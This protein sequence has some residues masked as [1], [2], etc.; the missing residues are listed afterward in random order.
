LVYLLFEHKSSQDRWLVL[1]LLIYVTRIWAWYRKNNGDDCR[2]PMILPI[3][4]YHGEE[5]WSQPLQLIDLCDAEGE[6]RELLGPCQPTLALTLIDLSQ[7]TEVHLRATLSHG[8]A[9]TT[10]TTLLMKSIRGTGLLR[11]FRSWKPVVGQIHAEAGGRQMLELLVQYLL[12]AARE[13]VD[14]DE[15]QNVLSDAIGPE[16]EELI[17]NTGEKLIQKGKERGLE[18]GRKE[19]MREGMQEGR[20]E[21]MKEALANV[22]RSRFDVIPGGIQSRMEAA[23]LETLQHYLDRAI[24]AQSLHEVFES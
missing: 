17:M 14:V 7:I 18:E 8:T 16:S 10:L 21:G 15:L 4:F 1:Q 12:V 3:V 11:R 24:T 23:D 5:R 20:R 2:L 22:L 6:T 19:G 13:E 9:L